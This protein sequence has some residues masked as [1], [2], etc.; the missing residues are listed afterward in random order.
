M[1]NLQLYHAIDALPIHVQLEVA[2]FVAFLSQK[3][4]SN[5][6]NLRTIES[7]RLPLKFGSAKGL[8][9]YLSPDWE[10]DID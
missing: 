3:Y 5:S 1:S 6:Q 8:I 2:D 4:N 9:K 7:N 10:N